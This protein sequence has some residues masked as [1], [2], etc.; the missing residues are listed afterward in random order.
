MP[1]RSGPAP[2]A[3]KYIMAMPPPIVVCGCHGGG[4]SF[5]TKLLRY[6]GL[7]AGAD[8]GPRWVRKYHESKSF[9]R[10][11]EEILLE[12]GGDRNG[13]TAS[14]FSRTATALAQNQ[15]VRDRKSVV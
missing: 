6:S 2:T 7:F 14:A 1:K 13:L 4:T 10:A 15:N 12:F 9:R 11:N 8:A 3:S 5:T